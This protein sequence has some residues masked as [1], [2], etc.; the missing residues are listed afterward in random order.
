[1]VQCI[2]AP[3][4]EQ[5]TLFPSVSLHCTPLLSSSLL[6]TP[7]PAPAGG[8]S[9]SL[10]VCGGGCACVWSAPSRRSLSLCVCV[11]VC[12]GVCVAPSPCPASRK[13]ETFILGE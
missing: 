11:W 8:L 3:T 13:H 4:V 2:Q 1:H 5:Q 10:C 9:L 6:S 7:L 12:W